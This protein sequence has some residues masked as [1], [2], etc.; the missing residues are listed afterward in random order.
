MSLRFFVPDQPGL[1]RHAVSAFYTALFGQLIDEDEPKMI[2][3]TQALRAGPNAHKPRRQVVLSGGT[4]CEVPLVCPHQG[5]PLN[6]DPDSDGI[7]QC[8]WHGYRLT[9]E[10]VNV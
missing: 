8:P 2:Y 9:P 10:R 7:M 4:I 6:C 5:L 1:D 3:R